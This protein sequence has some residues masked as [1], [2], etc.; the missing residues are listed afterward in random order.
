MNIKKLEELGVQHDWQLPL[1]LP[2]KCIDNSNPLENA[3]T[4]RPGQHAVFLL[5]VE[6]FAVKA[7]APY[8]VSVHFID[9]FKNRIQTTF[10]IPQDNVDAFSEVLSNAFQRKERL[11]VSGEA[12]IWNNQATIKSPKFLSDDECRLALT[13]PSG[14][15]VTEEEVANAA[16]FALQNDILVSNAVINISRHLNRTP[17]E[18]DQ[19]ISSYL[20]QEVSFK[21]IIKAAHQ[22]KTNRH[23]E[24]SL[25]VF[26][27][28]CGVKAIQDG[29]THVLTEAKSSNLQIPQTIIE[30]L[31]ERLPYS[32]TDEQLKIIMDVFSRLNSPEVAL[33]LISADVGYGK[34]VIFACLCAAAA[35][36]GS[37]SVIIE[38][39]EVL[40]GQ[41]ANNIREW[42][43][44]VKVLDLVAKNYPEPNDV[45]GC[46]VVG[47]TAINFYFEEHK[48]K[49]NL[50]VCDEEHRFGTEQKNAF[51]ADINYIGA[52]ATCIPR[53]LQ[54]ATLGSFNVH[55]MLKCH[56]K[57]EI[58]TRI[59]AMED[60]SVIASAIHKNISEGHQVIVIYPLALRKEDVNDQEHAKIISY[61]DQP[62]S[63]KKNQLDSL[64]VSSE[65][66]FEAWN[67][68]YPGLVSWI[69]G[70]MPSAEKQQN[71]KD[72]LSK[73]KPLLVATTAVE[74]GLD[75]KDV[76][77]L[78]VVHPD[79]M[80]GA[81]LH[82]L[83]G[84]LARA[85]GEGGFDMWMPIPRE[86]V[87][88][89]VAQRLQILVDSTD[90]YL[91]AEDDLLRR[92]FGE[93]AVGKTEQSGA[94]NSF[95]PTLKISPQIVK[96]TAEQLERIEL[97]ALELENNFQ[98]TKIMK[99]P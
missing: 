4:A 1:L 63:K 66:G 70:D 14:I 28:L 35:L 45:N 79:R 15:N 97:S 10:F 24:A 85:G 67:I 19:L 5:F 39:N 37:I 27:F 93:L 91:I 81:T 6:K 69:Y 96:D 55:R 33:E 83:R 71:F 87:K 42:W 49:P 11:L 50:I 7:G 34:T 30:N 40:A 47:T 20:N 26:R 77:H 72:F 88:K 59:L 22:P 3:Y 25:S 92:G 60:T 9:K 90:G 74:V 58:K 95:I 54:L 41:V 38:P 65:V 17:S 57:K 99:R 29:K 18:L 56:V 16:R 8:R 82:Q 31:I 13:Y 89:K 62:D 76:R 94:M 73:K 68:A 51:G 86:N 61:D 48:L 32:L 80:G 36:T 78:V 12:A 21:A 44:E 75:G 46:I 52:T 23:F 43:P 98:Q 84:R 53:T 2:T 64:L